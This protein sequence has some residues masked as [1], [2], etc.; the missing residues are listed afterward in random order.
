MDNDKIIIILLVVIIV[1]ILIGF[2]AFNPFKQECNISVVSADSLTVGD[3]FAI[4][5]SDSN[6][7]PVA[8]VQVSVSF[9]GSNGAVSTKQVTTDASGNAAVSLSDLPAGAYNVT[10][11]VLENNNYRESSVSKQIAVNEV[12][13]QVSQPTGVS[14]D[15]YSYYPQS[16][17]A[18]DS[19][20][21]TREYAMAHNMHYISQSID[22]MDAGVYVRYDSK[23]G[24][25]HT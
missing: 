10:C 18:V 2:L 14:D 4:Y 3:Q 23:A 8:N 7:N 25:Y 22:G 20:G 16:G 19:R 5:V 17:P 9:V 15:G 11:N 6:S 12:Q 1:M 13:T 24:S 21:I